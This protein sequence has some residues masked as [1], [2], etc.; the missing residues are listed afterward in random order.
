MSTFSTSVASPFGTRY[1]VFRP[2]WSGRANSSRLRAAA[3]LAPER[4]P[5]SA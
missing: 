1:Q 3:T 2:M 4:M 5:F